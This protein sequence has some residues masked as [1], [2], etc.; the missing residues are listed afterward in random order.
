MYL[1]TIDLFGFKSFAERT[2]IVLQ[3]GITG[4]IGPNG[5][6]KSNIMEAIRWC[7]GERSWKSLRSDSMVSIIFAGTSRRNPMNLCEVTL[8][9][10]NSTSMLPVQ[11][12]EVQ[13]TRRIYRS[14]ES[15]Y[16]IN[17]TQC[18][19][20]D[21]RE[22]FHDTG[23]GTDGYAILD[24]GG[25]DFVLT[26]KPEDRRAMFEEA[27]GVSKY[28]AKREEAIRKLDRLE[29]D[30][31]R[32]QDSISLIDEQVKKLD[33][34]ARKA[35][36]FKKYKAELGSMEA[37]AIIGD[38]G[39]I[40]TELGGEDERMAPVLEQVEALNVSTAADEGRL[41]AL[42]LERT[43]HDDAVIASNQRLSEIK[44]EIGRLEERLQNA[45]YST[46]ETKTQLEGSRGQLGEE[47]GRLAE[48]EPKL[49]QS[50]K[51]AQEAKEALAK[52]R[53]EH[54]A[55]HSEFEKLV[56]ERDAAANAERE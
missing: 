22:L 33:S 32:L 14:G 11:Y 39:R 45:Q 23:I 6:G 36:L 52:A 20:R 35:Q 24:Q 26:S 18:R 41:A 37:G 54:E 43:S 46:E 56:A 50:E 53:A 13:V 21:I 44:A 55:F 8:T 49:A 5:C 10:D 15:E 17:K 30:L 48:M 40:D 31:G 25:V 9:F 28:K 1:K 12:G 51:T 42:S 29:I 19:Q 7:I 3:P 16:Y 27:A 34:D 4:V 38:I 2:R 47:E